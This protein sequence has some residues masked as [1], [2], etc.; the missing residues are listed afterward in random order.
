MEVVTME[1]YELEETG[2]SDATPSVHLEEVYGFDPEEERCPTP[3]LDKAPPTPTTPTMHASIS[4]SSFAPSSDNAAFLAEVATRYDLCERE[5]AGVRG[6]IEFL[7]RDCKILIGPIQLYVHKLLS[8]KAIYTV[9][10]LLEAL[11][12]DESYLEVVVGKNVVHRPAILKAVHGRQVKPS[13]GKPQGNSM[14]LKDDEQR[15][16]SDLR[17]E[18]QFEPDSEEAHDLQVLYTTM[19]VTTNM[20]SACALCL[21]KCVASSWG[22]VAVDTVKAALLESN[23]P[24]ALEGLQDVT[25][26]LAEKAWGVFVKS[27]WEKFVGQLKQDSTNLVIPTTSLARIAVLMNAVTRTFHAFALCLVQQ[28]AA[29]ASWLTR[30]S[31]LIRP[32]GIE[33]S[34]HG[35]D[36]VMLAKGFVMYMLEEG[37]CGQ[38][39]DH[40]AAAKLGV[41]VFPYL[42]QALQLLGVSTTQHSCLA[43]LL[44][45]CHHHALG[46]NTKAQP[47]EAAKLYAK[48]ASQDNLAAQFSLALCYQLG[49]GVGQ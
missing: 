28:D 20:L 8:T 33:D 41:E 39:K 31:K 6:L 48:S 21:C 23:T 13:K 40:E 43:W 14:E 29:S 4:S 3:K 12:E 5:V 45:Y 46:T 11:Q 9:D 2:I 25:G 16:L 34:L 38:K 42:Q 18:L 35:H 32:E 37:I 47:D 22:C 26:Q 15:G 30:T 44:G 24:L 17:Q 27:S 49:Q 36:V 19:V 7:R 10:M 1:Q